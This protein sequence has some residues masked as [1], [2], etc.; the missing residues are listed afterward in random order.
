MFW[1]IGLC[2]LSSCKSDSHTARL[3]PARMKISDK[4]IISESLKETQNASIAYDF[5][6]FEKTT[7]P[8]KLVEISGLTI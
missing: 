4:P 8:K 2:I 1:I 3:G 7:L 5:E 6:A